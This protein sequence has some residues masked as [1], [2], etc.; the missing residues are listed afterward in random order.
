MLLA[1]VLA[2]VVL[3]LHFAYVSFVVF[4]LIGIVIGLGLKR[5]WARGFWLRMIHLA[6][7][8]IV[9]VQAWLGVV[10]P[11][12]RLENRLRRHAGQQAYPLD[13]IEYWTHKAMFFQAPAWVFIIAY[14]VFGLVVVST[15]VLG[16]PRWPSR[17][18]A[19]V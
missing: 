5:D 11:L 9:V 10:C 18:T 15:F 4:G 13:F 1:R 6:M 12:T 8:G 19:K 16:P 17:K 2:D 7:I 3:V 14:T